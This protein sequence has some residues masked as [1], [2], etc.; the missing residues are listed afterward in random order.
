MDSIKLWIKNRLDNGNF[1][2]LFIMLV[3]MLACIYDGNSFI[4]AVCFWSAGVVYLLGCHTLYVE[5]ICRK[6]KL[7][8]SKINKD[9]KWFWEK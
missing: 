7:D 3:V 1:Y 6:N 8:Q 2:L 9:D 4:V 5:N